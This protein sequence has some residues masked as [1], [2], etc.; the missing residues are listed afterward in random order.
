[1]RV[2]VSSLTSGKNHLD[3][4]VS[5]TSSPLGAWNVFRL[6]VQNDGTDGTP[7][8]NCQRRV[9]VNGVPTLVHG[10]CLGDYPHIGADANGFYITTNE[11]YFFTPGSFRGSQIYAMSKFAL[12]A[13]ASS[14]AVQQFDTVN[15]LLLGVPGFT[16]WPAT[17][18]AGGYSFDANGTEYFL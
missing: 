7:D 2:G 5:A 3:I 16:V 14:V 13:G 15:N 9:T 1:D 12:A 17:T 4:A 10:P 8:H 18:P 11:F 6:P